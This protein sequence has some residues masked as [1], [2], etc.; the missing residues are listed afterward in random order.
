[1]RSE[2]FD[3]HTAF[4]RRLAR[5]L[6]RDEARADDLVQDT[7]VAALERPPRD[8]SS[9]RAWLATV[10]RRRAKNDARGSG[11]RAAHEGRLAPP[12]KARGADDAAANLEL[13]REVCDL[14]L[15]LRE[16]YRTVVYLRYFEDLRPAEIAKRLG[17][18]PLTVKTR[19]ARGLA[20][21]RA[22]LDERPG[23]RA[24]W[25]ACLVA[26]AFPRRAA[27]L[28]VPALTGG[29]GSAVA[30][31]KLVLFVVVLAG[32]LLVW[33]AV[34]G[35]GLLP[36]VELGGRPGGE[37]RPYVEVAEEPA[38]VAQAPAEPLPER[39]PVALDA[40]VE[41]LYG[42]LL[43]RLRPASGVASD[44]AGVGVAL[45]AEGDPAPRVDLVHA[46]TD[47]GG[48]ARFDGVHAGE[49]KLFVDRGW[50]F[51]AEVVAGETSE[52]ELELPLG[53][54]VAGTVVDAA[55]APVGGAEIWVDSRHGVYPW[56]SVLATSWADGSFRLRGL[57]RYVRFG[58]R[59]SGH[60]PSPLFEHDELPLDADGTTRRVTLP[61]GASGRGVAGRVLDPEGH[62]VEGAVVLVGPRGGYNIDL[63]TGERVQAA[64]PVPVRTDAAGEFVYPG[65]V[66]PEPQPVHAMARGFPVWSGTAEPG[67][68][69]AWIE[70]Q[71]LAPATIHGRVVDSGGEPVAGARVVAAVE[72]GGGWFH[73]P[74]PSPR[75]ESDADGLF[76]LG[77]V[78]PGAQELNAR[79]DRRPELGKARVVAT[80]AAG[81]VTEVELVLDLGRTIR[82]HV[83]D[84]AGA[85]LAGWRV[86]GEPY[87]SGRVYPRSTTTDERGAFLLPNLGDCPW[88]VEIAAPGE[89]PHP[90][91]AVADPVAPNTSDLIVVVENTET[92]RAR[93]TGHLIGAGGRPPADARLVLY[94]VGGNTGTFV[95]FDG[96]SGAFEGSTPM[97]G[98]YELRVARGGSALLVSEP[99]EL[100][101][102]RTVDV[103]LLSLGELGRVD[104][105]LSGVPGDALE[106]LDVVL[107]RASMATVDTA[108]EGD[109]FLSGPV[110][111][112]EWIVR[113]R[114][115][116][117]FV[118]EVVAVA[119][120]GET[121]RVELEAR[122][123]YEV[124]LELDL[125]PDAEWETVQIVIR[126]ADGELVRHG[127]PWRRQRFSD[128]APSYFGLSLPAGVFAIE[129]TTDT[130]LAGF[131]ELVIQ[132]PLSGRGLAPVQVR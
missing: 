103:G 78:P 10:L 90:P 81:A 62:P 70:I 17:V 131:A 46:R 125:A 40:P 94:E 2:P 41:S 104:V 15:A 96:G 108:R 111:P 76:V 61:L 97:P 8:D 23:G 122:Q 4:L 132:D 50:S 54:D 53:T 52:V 74:L 32:A 42:A 84:S 16:P 80:C 86:F 67:D 85:P 75:A 47:E 73:D 13:A 63:P 95:D 56:G 37:V 5:G 65:D 27:P 127:G 21:L 87:A 12:G 101:R 60:L 19:L 128:R 118:P 34:G 89:W 57:G 88:A 83:V 38:V 93:F 107:E 20:E 126:D 1:M 58:A 114:S 43:V 92:E 91:R 105:R 64:T 18:P 66:G 49:V 112:G 99:F 11:R 71:L 51:D 22:R 48:V 45:Q 28:G 24:E 120:G 98:R 129:A 130:G 25:S 59:A 69:R 55:G 44:A 29:I 14:A 72:T 77:W 119:V 39:M 117:W 121:V 82:G 106:E 116:R 123:G 79:V 102:G 30:V 9:P 109:G 7:L 33:Q 36:G 31:K 113:V 6:V 68:G 35:G 110:V 115:E 3:R 100:E 124:D 26:I